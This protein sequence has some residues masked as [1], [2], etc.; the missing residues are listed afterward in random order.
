MLPSSDFGRSHLAL[1]NPWKSW[2]SHLIFSGG[3]IG[4]SCTSQKKF[5]VWGPSPLMGPGT[6]KCPKW[7]IWRPP[8]PHRGEGPQTPKFFWEV[9]DVPI[10]PPEKIKWLVQL[11]HGFFEPYVIYWNRLVCLYLKTKNHFGTRLNIQ[12]APFF[13]SIYM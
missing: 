8:G 9:Q 11:C 12:K 3:P 10:G 1:K 5:G 2:T 7:G 4:T 13:W 6:P